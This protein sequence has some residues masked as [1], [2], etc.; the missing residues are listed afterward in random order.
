VKEEGEEEVVVEEE[1]EE[2]DWEEE[3]VVVVEGRRTLTSFLLIPRGD[4][5]FDRGEG[6][7]CSSPPPSFS[8]SFLSFF[9]S[10]ETLSF[11][12]E[13]EDD[14][15][16]WTVS[17]REEVDLVPSEREEEEGAEREGGADGEE[18]EV[19]AEVVEAE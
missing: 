15:A 14:L 3:V 12:E 2:E 6:A 1:G 16:E 8:F 19:V 10:R 13:E 4:M 9:S 17:P 11:L 7:T 18:E 5:G